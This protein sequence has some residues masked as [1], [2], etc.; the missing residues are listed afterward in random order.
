MAIGKEA[1]VTET[2]DN[3]SGTGAVR[4]DGKIWSARLIG[5][6]ERAEVNE[7]VR[8]KKIEGVKLIVELCEEAV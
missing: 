3:L 4:L 7:K 8:V 6:D 5:E 2:I 1:V